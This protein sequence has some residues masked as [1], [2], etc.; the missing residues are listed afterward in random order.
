MTRAW[1]SLAAV[2]A[3]KHAAV[4]RSA[5]VAADTSSMC[6]SLTMTPCRS[7]P[8]EDEPAATPDGQPFQ[9]WRPQGLTDL[10]LGAAIQVW[11]PDHELGLK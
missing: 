6:R 3:L 7:D 1:S 9:E 4:K 8:N 10:Q 11:P 2:H 5:L